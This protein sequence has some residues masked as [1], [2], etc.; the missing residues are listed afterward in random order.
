MTV[1]M[2]LINRR[3]FGG[4]ALALGV[5]TGNLSGAAGL[6]ETLRAALKQR[7]I[8]AAVAMVATAGKTT[9]TGAFGK[10]DS[11][12]GVDVTPDSIFRIA[13][14]T[15]AITSTAAMQ[16]VE[17][18]TLELD[19]PVS[20]HLPE[21]AGLRVLEGFD[22]STGKPI[23][24]PAKPVLLKHLLTHTAGFAYDRWD[25]NLLKYLTQ[26]GSGS[27]VPPLVFEPGARWE[28]GISLDVT[29]RLVEKV[30]GLT[31]AEYFQRNILGPLGMVDTGFSVPGK[32]FDRMVSTW[33][34]QSDGFLTENP[35]TPP[36]D[37]PKSFN[38][39]GG[40]YSTAGDYVRFMQMILRRGKGGDNQVILQAKTVEMMASNQIGD[41]SAGKMKSLKPAESSDVDFH[42]G[43]TDGFGFGFLINSTAYEGGR[44]AGSLAWAGLAN[45]FYWI[46]PRRGVCA[47]LLMQ[48]LPFC[49]TEA[50]GTLRDFERAVYASLPGSPA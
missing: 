44:S 2:S 27:R 30:T 3:E 17:R 11:A 9:Y 49:D 28:Y 23:L 8:P 37:P 24:H 41:I 46:D 7:R 6:D 5:Q 16:L 48:F 20:K 19:E 47:V 29:G 12:S 15:K 50:M 32:K 26:P 33:Q 4:A 34:R 35:R 1:N 18:G 10:R 38:G 21:L 36:P 42:P 25:E 43:F 22:K 39:G 40:L 45:T 14:M 31:L 13:S